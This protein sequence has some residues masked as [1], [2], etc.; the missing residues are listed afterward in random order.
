MISVTKPNVAGSSRC[1]HSTVV[2]NWTAGG[3]NCAG[4]Y[5]KVTCTSFRKSPVIPKA[6]VKRRRLKKSLD[7]LDSNYLKVVDLGICT[8]INLNRMF[9][10]TQ[11][12][13]ELGSEERSE[14]VRFF[15]RGQAAPLSRPGSQ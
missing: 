5:S 6:H 14:Q 15:N 13:A 9:D 2:A 4:T 11:K 12:Q 8:P 10:E 3:T 1:V 7:L